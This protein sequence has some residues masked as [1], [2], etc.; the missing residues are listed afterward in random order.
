M[1]C[2]S[3]LLIKVERYSIQKTTVCKAIKQLGGNLDISVNFASTIHNVQGSKFLHKFKK[4]D[5]G[6][7]NITIGL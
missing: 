1:G 7:K 3:F 5:L 4:S 2:D 6:L